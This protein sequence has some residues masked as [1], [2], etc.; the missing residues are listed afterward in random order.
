MCFWMFLVYLPL[1]F[2]ANFYILL[3]VVSM[4]HEVD[5][6]ASTPTSGRLVDLGVWVSQKI[7]QGFDS[8]LTSCWILLDTRKSG[9]LSNMELH[10]F[11][12]QVINVSWTSS[13]SCKL[14]NGPLLAEEPILAGS[15]YILCYCA[16]S[17]SGR[18]GGLFQLGLQLVNMW[19]QCQT[20]PYVYVQ[21]Y[22]LYIHGVDVSTFDVWYF[23]IP[24]FV[25]DRCHVG[26]YVVQFLHL[27]QRT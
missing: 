9:H 6:T 18:C 11:G 23:V 19:R 15:N 10:C 17:D 8:M 1:I 24:P 12:N 5:S 2:N 20:C 27:T 7:S 25:G 26:R 22:I 13:P 21:L 4:N 16:G 3:H 14:V